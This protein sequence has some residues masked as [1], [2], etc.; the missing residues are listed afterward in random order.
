MNV[1]EVTKLAKNA[2]YLF[3]YLFVSEVEMTKT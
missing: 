2:T 3:I 1:I